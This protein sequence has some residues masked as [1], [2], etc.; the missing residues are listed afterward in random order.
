MSDTS[1]Q[2]DLFARP[3]GEVSHGDQPNDLSDTIATSDLILDRQQHPAWQL[4]AARRAPLVIGCLKPLFENAGAEIPLEDARARLTKMLA[5]HANNPDFEIQTD[6][7]PALARLVCHL[8]ASK[9]D[10]T[11]LKRTPNMRSCAA[12]SST[13][14]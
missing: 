12:G 8:S 5:A 4:L 1:S 11:R 7:F 2:A 9:L 14:R 10:A 13:Y 3:R 6:D